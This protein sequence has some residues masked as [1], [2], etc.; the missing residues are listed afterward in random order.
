MQLPVDAFVD[1]VASFA[2]AGLYNPWREPHEDD[3]AGDMVA[4]RKELLAK[5]LRAPMPSLLL[6][7]EAGNYFTSRVTGVPMVSEHLLI[8]ERI[9]RLSIEQ[10]ISNGKSPVADAAAATIWNVL[11]AE[12]V[13]ERTLCWDILPWQPYRVAGKRNRAPA[14]EELMLGGD[15]LKE[16]LAVNPNALVVGIGARARS[17]LADL[18]HGKTA[19][20][21]TSL[22]R[23]NAANALAALRRTVRLAR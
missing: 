2:Q 5:H 7:G 8:N 22:S 19:T 21:I 23:G 20:F 15:L 14:E 9:P 16:L 18:G 13:A 17:V 10:Q 4:L 1:G 3:A 12:G 11:H 6:I